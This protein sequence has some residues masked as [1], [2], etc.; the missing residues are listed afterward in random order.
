MVSHLGSSNLPCRATEDGEDS[1]NKRGSEK[2]VL[3]SSMMPIWVNSGR[4]FYSTLV[5]NL[6]NHEAPKSEAV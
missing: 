5:D 3:D 1:F 4:F 2:P 6:G